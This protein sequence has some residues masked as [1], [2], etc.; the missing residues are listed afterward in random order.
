MP[1]MLTP[2]ALATVASLQKFSLVRTPSPPWVALHRLL[3]PQANLTQAA[4]YL[5]QAFGGEEMAYK[6]AGGTKWWQVRAGLGVEAEWIAMK[7]EKK[8]ADGV[9]AKSRAKGGTGEKADREEGEEMVG[10]DGGVNEDGNFH[11]GAYYWGSI[12]T[13]RYTIWRYARKMKGRCFAVNYRK[14]PQYPFPC[15]LQDCLAA[16]LYLVRPP[17]GAKHRPV[18]PKNMIIAGDSAGGGLVWALL[19]ILRDTEGLELPAGGV[20]ISPK[21][22]S[23]WPPPPPELTTEMQTRLRTRV[24]EAV[25][26]LHHDKSATPL[27]S[28]DG[29]GSGSSG[30]GSDGVPDV[31]MVTHTDALEHAQASKAGEKG[32]GAKKADLHPISKKGEAYNQPGPSSEPRGGPPSRADPALLFDQLS[33]PGGR[34]PCLSQFNTGLSLDVAGKEVVLDTQIQLYATNATLAHPWVSPVMGY[35]GGLPPL[36]IIAGQNEVLRDEIIY[37][38]HKAAHPEEHPIKDSIKKL[39]PSLNGIEE[40]Y[41]PT[42]VHLQVYDAPAS[43]SISKTPNDSGANTPQMMTSATSSPAEERDPVLDSPQSF[44]TPAQSASDV[45]STFAAQQQAPV[46]LETPLPRTGAGS[47]IIRSGTDSP[48]K[49]FS[50]AIPRNRSTVDNFWRSGV[51]SSGDDAGPRFEPQPNQDGKALPGTAGYSGIYE[52]SNPFNNHMIRERVDPDGVCRPLEAESDLGAMTMPADE[53]GVIK[54]GPAMRYLDGQAAWDKKFSHAIKSVKRHR[55]RNLK[56]SASKDAGKLRE[57]WSERVKKHDEKKRK[58]SDGL[59]DEDWED[60][61]SVPNRAEFLI[62]KSWSWTWALKGEA[63]PP[64]SIVSRRDFTEARQ[65]ALMADRMSDDHA[66]VNG[67]SLWV[68]LASF[69][70]NSSERSKAQDTLRKAKEAKKRE[71]KTE[72]SGPKIGLGL[73]GSKKKEDKDE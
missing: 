51:A 70:S 69:F 61:E 59:G 62:D 19:Q 41:G 11:G 43:L 17:P 55:E 21:P 42:D 56:I 27:T 10:E 9:D 38:A 4:D 29:S 54:E 45:H 36:L 23:L 3:I 50:F 37:A 13:H 6:V 71:K 18:D 57:I 72:A 16:Y 33:E 20:L 49:K 32:F 67:L 25:A 26:R 40:R 8:L 30:S 15:A 48:R 12:N 66:H 34:M 1:D 7:K 52:G 64:S 28:T 46:V 5:I 47:P 65:L 22:S 63:P 31:P 24:K 53:I 73:F 68:A 39:L 60:D 14:A 2:Q 35:L 44:S 58:E